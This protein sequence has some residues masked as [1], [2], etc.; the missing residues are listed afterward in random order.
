MGLRDVPAQ[1]QRQ[2][3]RVLRGGHGVR[4]GRVGDDDAALGG[5]LDVDVVDAGAGAADHLQAL[6]ARDQLGGHLRRGADDDRVE[7]ADPLQQLVVG[8]LEAE[9]DL[10]VL[11]QELH[12]ALGDLLLHQHAV[13]GSP[14]RPGRRFCGSAHGYPTGSGAIPA[15]AKVR[16]TAAV[17]APG[18]QSKPASRSA[19][20]SAPIAITMSKA[21]K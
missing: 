10:E 20:S 8:H 21:P 14:E 7:L 19:S 9:L 15:S 13:D 6:G 17:P 12:A 16:C 4:L 3:Q 1:R 18:S 2:R 5:R 11:S